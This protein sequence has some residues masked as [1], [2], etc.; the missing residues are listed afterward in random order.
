VF[1]KCDGLIQ[2]LRHV[3]TDSTVRS[4]LRTIRPDGHNRHCES[5]DGS[6]A[7]VPYQDANL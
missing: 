4:A 3:S 6:P 7:K 1:R 2:N 5:G